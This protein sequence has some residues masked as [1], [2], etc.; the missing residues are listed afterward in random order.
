MCA[1]RAASSSSSV[2][3]LKEF[4]LRPF[5]SQCV[6]RYAVRIAFA[7]DVMRP[8]HLDGVAVAPQLHHTR[9]R[10]HYIQ[11]APCLQRGQWS[12]FQGVQHSRAL[13]RCAG[14]G[15][16][17]FAGIRI[18]RCAPASA[19]GFF[20][21]HHGCTSRSLAALFDARLDPIFYLGFNKSDA[22]RAQ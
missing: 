10:V 18:A 14:I 3:Q 9:R 20:I 5:A 1:Q 4:T 19:T 2:N 17:A 7:G 15:R 16:L 13:H 12:P 11:F 8:Y 22:A 21:G 6:T